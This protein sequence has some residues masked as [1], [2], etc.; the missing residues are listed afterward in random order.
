MPVLFGSL[1][2]A[3]ALLF[4]SS[5]GLLIQILNILNLIFTTLSILAVVFFGECNFKRLKL[6]GPYQVGYREFRSAKHGNEVSVYYPMDKQ[7]YEEQITSRNVKWL[8]HGQKT[9]Q[10]LAMASGKN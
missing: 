2:L 6:I 7:R 3:I 9:L 10:G 8:R 1:V 5:E 4:S